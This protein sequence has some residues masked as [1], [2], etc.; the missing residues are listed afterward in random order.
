MVSDSLHPALLCAPLLAGPALCVVCLY[1]P[2]ALPGAWVGRAVR[3]LLA[4][5]FARVE[6]GAPAGAHGEPPPPGAP[7]LRLPPLVAGAAEAQARWT[8]VLIELLLGARRR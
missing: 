1:D 7:V 6:I 5:A 4:R 3:A 2:R 8:L